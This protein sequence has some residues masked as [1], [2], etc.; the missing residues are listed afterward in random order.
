MNIKIN[1]AGLLCFLA[2]VL[3]GIPSIVK[4]E[5]LSDFNEYNEKYDKLVD[6]CGYILASRTDDSPVRF[7]NCIWERDKILLREY[8]FGDLFNNAAYDRYAAHFNTAKDVAIARIDGTEGWVKYWATESAHI[9]L[10]Y[11]K[12]LKDIALIR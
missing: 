10:E 7:R 12:I 6:R 11:Y 2:I 3:L 8:R 4:A 5:N 9:D 1:L